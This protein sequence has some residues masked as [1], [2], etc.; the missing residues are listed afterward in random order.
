MP[1]LAKQFSRSQIELA[2]EHIIET[3]IQLQPSTVHDLV[4]KGLKFPPKEVVRMAAKLANFPVDESYSLSGG[5]NTNDPLKALGFTIAEK[6]IHFFSSLIAEYKNRL[7]IQGLQD[8]IYKWKLIQTFKGHPDPNAPNFTEEVKTTEFA[9]LVYGIGI[10]AIKHLA[11]KRP[12]EYRNCYR[13]LFDESQALSERV[14]KF[15]SDVTA[16]YRTLVPEERLSAH[17]DERTIATLLTYHNPDQYTFFKDSF[18]QILCQRLGVQSKAVGYKY[19]H[20]LEIV[21]EFINDYIRADNE[22]LE[23]INGNLD[24]ECYPDL[25]H[26]LLAQDILYTILEKQHPTFKN[27]VDELTTIVTESEEGQRFKLLTKRI[28]SDGNWEWIKLGDCDNIIKGPMAHYEVSR[29]KKT[30]TICVALHFED[31]KTNKKFKEVI[32][33][34]LID[35]LYWDKWYGGQS[36]FFQQRLAISEENLASIIME[37]LLKI[38]LNYGTLVKAMIQNNFK[39]QEYPTK[40]ENNKMLHPKNQI[41]YGPPGTGKTFHTV[42]KALEIIEDKTADEIAKEDREALLDRFNAYK[43]QGKIIF[44]T[45]HQSLG[46]EDFVEGIK[47]QAPETDG[48]AISY[49]VEPG[50]FKTLCETARRPAALHAQNKGTFDHSSFYKM[51]IGGKNRPDIHDWCLE[52]N[53]IGLGYGQDKDFSEF[54]GIKDWS[55][56]RDTFKATFPELVQES[57]YN[58]Q[59]MFTFQKM[60]IGDIVVITKGNHVIDAIG[61]ITGPYFYDDNSPNEYCQFRKVEWLAKNINQSPSVFF[62][63]NISQQTIYEFYEADVKKEAFVSFFQQKPNTSNNYVMIIDEINRGNVSAIFGELITLIEDGKRE[64]CVEALEVILPYSKA[65]FSVPDNVYIVGTMNTADRSVEALDSALRR[66]FYF[67]EMMPDSSLV[68]ARKMIWDLWWRFP[69]VGWEDKTYIQYEN[70]IHNLLGE[71]KLVALEGKEK[72]KIWD[73]MKSGADETVFADL[74]FGLDLGVKLDRIN[75]RLEKLLS[76]DHT[77]GHTF[78]LGINTEED[79]YKAFFNKIIPLLQEYFFGDYG[80]IGLVLGEGFVKEPGTRGEDLF[81][82]FNYED[83]DLLLEKKVYEINN[84]KADGISFIDAVKAI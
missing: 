66:R 44:T 39:E 6:N 68:S 23:I 51:S 46:Y 7:N 48:G 67:K 36:L 38:E 35:G 19:E 15:R 3:Q 62:E 72:D 49:E 2:L 84:F 42:N 45:F 43:A 25:N 65:A 10:G 20:Y 55:T 28:E 37:M 26:T 81:A 50:I 40:K 24:Q 47:P 56:Y 74:D 71:N 58:I 5:S 80:K 77:I 60:Q 57:R 27:I 31:R 78:F 9:N 64:G 21:D 1:S 17:H 11:E 79:L 73:R 54:A 29:D 4:Y 83:R 34:E 59:A 33:T 16:V 8:E 18:Y 61:R 70:A 13:G 82:A 69:D 32:G 75:R 22:L 52:N 12:E 14:V 53:R 63:K 41:L 76:R 30:N